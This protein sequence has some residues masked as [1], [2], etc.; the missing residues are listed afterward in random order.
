MAQGFVGLTDPDWHAFLRAQPRVDEV[1][2]W[3]PHGNKAFR[4]LAPGEMFFFKLR[5]PGRAIGGFGFF[6]RHEILPAWLAWECF[7]PMNGASTFEAMMDR[8]GRLRKDVERSPRDR[9]VRIGCILLSAPAFFEPDEWVEPPSDWARTGIQ[10]GKRYDLEVGEGRRI[11][12]QCLERAARH[13]D[14]WNVDVPDVPASI[15]AEDA[16][17]YG[18][19]TLVRPRLGQGLFR[20]AVRDAYHGACAITREHSSPVLEAAHIKP[21]A[22]GGRHE[23]RN[24]ILLRSDLHKLF[25]LGYVTVTPDYLFKVGDRL[26]DEFS[27]GRS[28]YGLQG[29]EL[30]LPASAAQ[31]PDRDLLAWHGESVFR[32]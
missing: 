6:E 7:G 4:V 16:A 29:T 15:V 3:Q 8:I 25:D 18:S 32:G 9:D 5:S 12:E 23:L 21:Y 22:D 26:R 1:N 27:N 11:R 10:V 14:R 19:P 30:G 24:G 17:R 28:Y 13:L 31:R 20:L 2:F